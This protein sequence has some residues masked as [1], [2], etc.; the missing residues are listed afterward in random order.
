PRRRSTLCRKSTSQPA[1]MLRSECNM[2]N[3]KKTIRTGLLATKLGMTRLF[4]EHAEHVPV[5]VLH[6]D[7]CQVVGVRSKDKHGYVALQ[8]GLGNAKVKNVSK[9]MRGYY[10][11]AKVEPKA[12][13]QEFRVTE[14][15]V[16]EVGAQLKA[17]HFKVGQFVDV[18]S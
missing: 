7:N 10:G 14:D 17:D 15:A 3:A 1:S 13:L 6:V 4:V 11:Q 8:V 18:C 9:P 2:S 5:T 16:L 12:E